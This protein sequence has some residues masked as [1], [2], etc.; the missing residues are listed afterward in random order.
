MGYPS[1]FEYVVRELHFSKGCTWRRIMVM[2]LCRE[3]PGIADKLRSGELNLT[4]ASQ[5]QNAIEKRARRVAREAAREAASE[6]ANEPASVP[7]AGVV[8]LPAGATPT[9]G[10]AADSAAGG[11][12]VGRGAAAACRSRGSR[13]SRGGGGVGT[14]ASRCRGSRCS[15]GCSVRYGAGARRSN[16]HT[17]HGRAVGCRAIAGWGV[18]DRWALDAWRGGGRGAA[19]GGRSRVSAAGVG[20][21]LAGPGS[22]SGVCAGA[23]RS[24]TTIGVDP[25][26]EG[27]TGRSGSPNKSARET[28][29]AAGGTGAGA[30]P[31]A[32]AAAGP[33][34][35]PLRG[36]G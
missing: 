20:H 12:G 14:G 26:S 22:N 31:A 8:P 17:A 2:K 16:G 25:R 30:G 35:R 4:T 24:G 34:R 10:A 7:P 15:R 5:L 36:C 9:Q 19:A 11:V 21:T 28:E 29:E 23:T 33:R 1:L 27:R 3:V 6:R 13:G 32:G 18:G